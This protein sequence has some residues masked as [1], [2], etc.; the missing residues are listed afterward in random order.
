MEALPGVDNADRAALGIELEADFVLVA[1]PG[2]VDH[3]GAGLTERQTDLIDTIG[4][5]AD[6]LESSDRHCPHDADRLG[7]AG[8]AERQLEVHPPRPFRSSVEARPSNVETRW[9]V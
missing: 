6:A 5:H 2:V 4:G 7:V 1:V 8:K 3:V 9:S